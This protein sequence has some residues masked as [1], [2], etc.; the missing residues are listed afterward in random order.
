MRIAA[1]IAAGCALAGAAG[2]E[3][4]RLAGTWP[5]G[6]ALVAVEE[7][8]VGWPSSSPF[9]PWDALVGNAAPTEATGTLFLPRRAPGARPPPAVVMLHG[10]SGVLAPRELTYGRQFAAMGIAA[11][12]VDSFAAR[13]DLATGFTDRLL[14]ITETML[15]ADAYAALRWLAA[16]GH[17][18]PRRVALVGFSYGAMA[19]MYALNAGVARAL[20]PAGE[21]FAA[22]AAFY[23]PCIASFADE[24]TTG[25]PLL[26]LY[27][28]EDGLIDPARCAAT[29][30]SFR[31]GGSRVEVIAYEGAAHQWDGGRGP[32]R[33]GSLLN[34]CR[35]RLEHD[36]TVRD[37]NSGLPMAGS[38]SRR[39][40]L[41]FC[42]ERT[43]YLIRDDP[44]VRARSNA[45]L[46]RFLARALGA[47]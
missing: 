17:A 27:G 13:R 42:I 30:E 34:G 9:T 41:A 2:A 32:L 45:D 35:L 16:E 25:A 19:T 38:F 8:R 1:L 43:P 14:N 3:P 22:H 21:R 44:A 31:R 40:I 26:I 24:R 39:L 37:L 47:G 4:A 15:L 46:G 18:D 7:R 6:D 36:G 11:L 33:I 28:T 23:G 5:D 29:A 10:S 12:A 20:A